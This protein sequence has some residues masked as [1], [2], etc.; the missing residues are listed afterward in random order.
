MFD[1]W[2]FLVGEVT[3]TVLLIIMRGITNKRYKYKNHQ[4]DMA[5]LYLLEAE[6]II[7]FTILGIAI[8]TGKWPALVEDRLIGSILIAISILEVIIATL[9]NQYLDKLIKIIETERDGH[10]NAK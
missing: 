4:K 6:G 3:G 2:L 1:F 9:L 7:V 8:F 10:G 5:I